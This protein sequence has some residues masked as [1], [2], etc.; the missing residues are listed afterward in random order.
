METGE[1][2]EKV[3]D[4]IKN[5]DEI[6]VGYLYGSFAKGSYDEKSDVDVGLLLKRGYKPDPLYESRISLELDKNIGRDV[7]ARILND[8]DIIFLHQILK[9]GKLVF[10][11]T[12]RE[13]IVFETYTYSKYLDFLPF[14][15]EYNRIRRERLLQ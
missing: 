12:E 13:R 4:V 6:M 15:E 5:H 9:Y 14:Y 11:R 7:E 8:K 2:M 1:I 10:S 3:R